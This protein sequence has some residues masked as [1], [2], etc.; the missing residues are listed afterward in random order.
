MNFSAVILAG[1][2]SSRMGCDKAFAEVNGQTL[3]ARQIQLA[4]AAGAADIFISGRPAVDYSAF[5]LRV[6]EDKFSD[7]G[8]LAGIHSALEATASPLLLVLAVDLPGMTVNFLRQLV[9]ACSENT[10]AVPRV[11]GNLEPLAAIYPK[12][13]LPLA[14]QL[15][16]QHSLSVKKFALRCVQDA[17]V[18]FTDL[19]DSAASFFVNCNSPD[20]LR[21]F[22]PSPRGATA[23]PDSPIPA[24]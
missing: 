3:L 5:G 18:S 20:D 10:G 17:L 8:P 14:T 21:V 19:P 15:L 11:A 1:G 6:L 13:A 9:A 2:R 16:G 7:A 23:S 22:A 12:A 24:R 4:H